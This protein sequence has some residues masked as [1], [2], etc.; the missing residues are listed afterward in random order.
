M[1]FT[2]ADVF[3]FVNVSDIDFEISF[4]LSQGLD[5]FW[6]LYQ[7]KK[8]S[9]A[10]EGFRASP[11]SKPEVKT[12]TIFF[13]NES[14]PPA[15][16]LVWLKRQ[17]NVLMPLKPVYNEEGF[18]VVGWK[19][20]VRLNVQNNMTQHLPNSFF[21]GRERGVCF[22]PGQPRQCYK[23]GSRRHLAG[24]CTIKMCTL[25]GAQGHVNKDC[26]NVR[27]NLCAELGHT[28]RDCPNACHNIVKLCPRIE[29]EIFQ[30]DV[31][32]E[33]REE[34]GNN[35]VAPCQSKENQKAE[36]TVTSVQGRGDDWKVAG[37]KAG[38]KAGKMI[39]ESEIK[40]SNRFELPSGKSWGDLAEEEEELRRIGEEK[41]RDEGNKKE[42]K[43]RVKERSIKKNVVPPSSGLGKRKKDSVLESEGPSNVEKGIVEEQGKKR[44]G[45]I[46]SEEEWESIDEED[47]LVEGESLGGM[48]KPQYKRHAEHNPVRTTN[49]PRCLNK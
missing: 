27:C 35:E 17:C 18:W 41:K 12:V 42:V 44:K 23:C 22:Y 40:T 20:Q 48:G 11:V 43:K 9:S 33:R 16:V 32:E 21:I 37:K 46:D 26:E 6:N 5:R 7:D 39:L 49:S 2:P 10:W 28:H 13:K 14:V 4:K 38:K 29:E 30:E 45:R 8:T 3:A 31:T 36:S 34:E 15:D 47:L 1:G 19:T 24:D 25:C